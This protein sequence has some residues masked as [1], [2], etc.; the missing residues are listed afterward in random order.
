MGTNIIA[1]MDFSQILTLPNGLQTLSAWYFLSLISVSV[2][3]IHLENDNRQRNLCGLSA[4]GA[5]AVMKLSTCCTIFCAMKLLFRA[6]RRSD[7]VR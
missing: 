3:E 2:F 1:T 6:N 5:K 7:T 4:R